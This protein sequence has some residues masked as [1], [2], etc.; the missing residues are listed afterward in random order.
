MAEAGSV[1]FKG[2]LW[3]AVAFVGIV[4]YYFYLEI[5][6]EKKQ[7]EEKALSEKVLVFRTSEVDEFSIIRKEQAIT[8]RRKNADPWEIVQPLNAKADQLAVETFLD[9]L[10]DTKY[11]RVVEESPA[12]LALFGLKDP[13]TQISIK[14]KN[15]DNIV[16]SIG[17]KSPIG[18]AIYLKRDDQT[19]VLLA[20]SSPKDW[21]I[22][23]F[24]LRDKSIFT[25]KTQDVV[26]VE[27]QKTGASLHLIKSNNVWA[28][29]GS[30]KAK[31][32][33]RDIEDMLNSLRTARIS[34][35]VE[36]NPKDL[37][38]FGLSPHTIKV[39]VQPA[40][41][42]SVQSL[43]IGAKNDAGKYFAKIEQSENVFVV[44]ANVLGALSKRDL[45]L[46]DKSLLDF[47]EENIA[48][49]SVRD[50]GEIILLKRDAG[51]YK[52][53]KI[54]QPTHVESDSAAVNSLLQDLKEARIGAYI[55]A[56]AED[57][58]RLELDSPQKQLLLV[59]KEKKSA[60][61]RIGKQS[62]DK[63]FYYSVREGEKN[64]FTLQAD[65]VAKL[66]RSLHDLRNKKILKFKIDDAAKVTI[67]Y[68]DKTFELNRQGEDWSL[69]L[70]KPLRQVKPFIGKDILWTLNNLEYESVENISDIKADYGF[71]H[72]KVRIAIADKQNKII[73]SL[74][75]G[76]QV[77]AQYYARVEGV[78]DVY[79]IKERFMGEIPSDM[80]KFED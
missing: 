13:A 32:D 17:D 14:T 58:A 24:D 55:G 15:P 5:P 73:A 2:T 4:L 28:V 69:S 10:R 35:F 20:T 12:D 57:F 46:L 70:P 11:S 79:R 68:Q 62:D 7:K 76:G 21:D 18:Q 40:E 54:E 71:D 80:K 22:S 67:Q 60:G 33:S 29:E 77:Q 65:T 16:L 47:K 52:S 42:S 61:I 66:I 59:T 25:Y 53:W 27:I 63:K 30:V 39:I 45:D 6:A 26:E 49:M 64:V 44:D 3:L 19:R 43:L 8:V 23:L 50:T 38:G 56:T 9:K 74:T 72:P 1:K 37:A 36:E 34:G 41:K 51:D 31:G 75:V 48:E 78:P